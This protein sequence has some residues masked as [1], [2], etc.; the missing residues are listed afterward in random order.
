MSISSNV[1]SNLN[2]TTSINPDHGYI[3]SYLYAT[4][5]TDRYADYLSDKWILE[6]HLHCKNLSVLQASFSI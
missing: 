5:D 2:P 3:E 4:D 6:E 1:K